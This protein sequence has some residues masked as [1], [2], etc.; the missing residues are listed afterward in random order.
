VIHVPF[1]KRECYILMR[2]FEKNRKKETLDNKIRKACD[3]M[4]GRTMKDCKRFLERLKCEKKDENLEEI[5]YYNQ[6]F[7]S[8]YNNQ[9]VSRSTNFFSLMN[10][11]SVNN[12][13]NKIY[14]KNKI[15]KFATKKLNSSSNLIETSNT[16]HEVQFD[17]LGKGY[18]AICFSVSTDRNNENDVNYPNDSRV[19][20]IKTGYTFYY[21][22]TFYYLIFCLVHYLIHYLIHY[23][24]TFHYLIHYYYT[25]YY[26]ILCFFLF[27]FIFLLF[28]IHLFYSGEYTK[29]VGH[30]QTVCDIKFSCDSKYILSCGLDGTIRRWE[31]FDSSFIPS[32]SFPSLYKFP[33]NH[34]LKMDTHPSQS[35]LFSVISTEKK[36]SVFNKDTQQHFCDPIFKKYWTKDP[37]KIF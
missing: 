25:F 21:L 7:F 5:I 3:L 6:K 15:E 26:L 10:E 32:F 34:F 9:L 19:W 16:P 18:L 2:E 29:L 14:F 30:S 4:L 23:L 11:R 20:N 35:L 17:P 22:N 28:F 8:K 12:I 27:H 24:N 33:K 13:K 37:V 31:E 36:L 1:S